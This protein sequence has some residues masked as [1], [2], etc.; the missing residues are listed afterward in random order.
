MDME[1]HGSIDAKT[2]LRIER[3]DSVTPRNP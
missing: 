3:G 1:I 2:G